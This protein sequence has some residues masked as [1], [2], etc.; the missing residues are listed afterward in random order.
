MAQKKILLEYGHDGDIIFKFVINEW[1]IERKDTY[2]YYGLWLIMGKNI[3]IQIIIESTIVTILGVIIAL[4]A[5]VI[6][7]YIVV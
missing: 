3:L 6:V 2:N 7:N 5:V 1:Y 4:T